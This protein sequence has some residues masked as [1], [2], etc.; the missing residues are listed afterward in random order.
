MFSDIKALGLK[1]Q[2][3][4]AFVTGPGRYRKL[5]E[6]GGRILSNLQVVT[7]PP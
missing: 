2:G 6:K 1:K 7:P 4:T 3:C 5:E